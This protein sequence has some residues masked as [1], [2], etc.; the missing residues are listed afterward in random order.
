MSGSRYR[1]DTYIVGAANRLAVS[2]ARAVAEAPGTVYN[3]L[4]IYSASG[5]GKTHL[6]AAMGTLGRDAGVFVEPASAAGYVGLVQARARGI[7]SNTDNVVL[8]LTG[9]GFE[10]IKSAVKAAPAP[11]MVGSLADIA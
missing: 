11:R 9:S 3:P 6:L 10:D 2:A 7:L 5:L 1:L 4:F 8:Q